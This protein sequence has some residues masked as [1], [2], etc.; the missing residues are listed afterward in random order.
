MSILTK[1]FLSLSIAASLV[2]CVKTDDAPEAMR[3][4]VPT[5]EQVAI[6]LPDTSARTIGELAEWYVATRNVTRTF[7][8]GSAWV[9]TLVHTIVQF[10]VT[11]SN[12]NEYTWGPWS[13]ALDPAEYRLDV[14]DNEDGTYEY[15][16]YGRNKTEAGA[17]FEKV[18]G[19]FANTNP[20]ELQGNGTFSVDFEAGRRVNPVDADDARGSFT[21]NYDLA[22]RHLDLVINSIDDGGNTVSADYAYN[23]SATGEGD[24][25]FVF[26]NDAGGTATTEQ[27]TLRSRWL[28]TG[29]GRA[30]ARITGGDLA[31]SADAS[32]CWNEQFRRTFYTDTADFA[33]TEGNAAE[34]AYATADL[35]QQ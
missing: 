22:E 12:G 4:A 16:L 30:D 10:P 26:D 34:C 31:V 33:P 19:G 14:T 11:S 25:V 17:G 18:I 6:N 8:G 2:A 28:A 23:E 29:A 15:A 35:P 32:E 24:M 3:T 21:A 27:V 1:S 5:A 7:N 13:D 9:L 20:G